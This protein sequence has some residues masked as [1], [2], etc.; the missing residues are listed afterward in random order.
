MT[1]PPEGDEH[2][3]IG[4]VLTLL[5]AEF[6]D[7][8][9]SKIRFLE[10]Q[11]L[12]APE[13]TPSGYRKF[14][15]PDVDRLRWILRQQK[16][17]YLPLKVIKGRLT[18][19]DARRKG[20]DG[21]ARPP[22]TPAVAEPAEVVAAAVLAV[23][24]AVDDAGVEVPVGP[25]VLTR[26][27]LARRSGLEPK[28]LT[29]LE[30]YGLL[31][32]PTSTEAG[33]R[34]DEDALALARLARAFFDKGVEP[35]HLRMYRTFVDRE[36]GFVEQLIQPHLRQRNPDARRHAAET[37]VELVRLGSGMRTALVR[38]ALRRALGE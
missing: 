30:N 29:E 1:A 25:V 12:I 24:G 35:R 15:E 14:R 21:D 31:P 36:M 10:S 11:G 23:D 33:P 32:A 6:P 8:T 37:A 18:Q 13:R 7:V 2:L 16:E 4:D 5:Q 17:H 19:L 38:I 27:E 3:S 9:V 34:Y 28:V 26:D 22:S 20:S